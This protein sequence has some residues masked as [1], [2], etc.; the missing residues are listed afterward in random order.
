MLEDLG[1]AVVGYLD[2]IGGV[3]IY[4]YILVVI[5]IF[6]LASWHVGLND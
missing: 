1:P 5:D 4:I 3:Y 2:P 6:T